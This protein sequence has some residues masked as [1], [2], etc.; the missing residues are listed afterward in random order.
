MLLRTCAGALL[1]ATMGITALVGGAGIAQ[2]DPD[3]PL[4][5][6]PSIG[7]QGAHSQETF[8]NPSN[9]GQ[10]TGD[11]GDVG[12]VCENLLDPCRQ[13]PADLHG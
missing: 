12:M 10:P 6:L 9:E 8:I 1:A 3:I 4:P 7:D 2:A 11:T 5:P 13:G